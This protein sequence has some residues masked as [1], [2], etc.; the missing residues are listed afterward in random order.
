LILKNDVKHKNFDNWMYSYNILDY[1]FSSKV[2]EV[3][4]TK[5]DS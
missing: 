1:K 4:K 3:N 2:Y 5:E